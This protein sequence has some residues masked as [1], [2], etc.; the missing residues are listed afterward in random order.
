M[1]LGAFNLKNNW[2]GNE[3][4]ERGLGKLDSLMGDQKIAAL[5]NIPGNDGTIVGP[6][7]I[8]IPGV[9]EH[10][11][12][13]P[14]GYFGERFPEG[15]PAL[16]YAPNPGLSGPIR[17]PMNFIQGGIPVPEGVIY[18]DEN[19]RKEWPTYFEGVPKGNMPVFTY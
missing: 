18:D 16:E 1:A 9:P 7:Q 13:R 11:S 8:D 6:T 10:Q 19:S 5:V 2:M 4:I 17:G 15:H 14:I 12:V 3:G